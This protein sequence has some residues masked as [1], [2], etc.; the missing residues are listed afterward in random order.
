MRLLDAN[1]LL[2]S[3]DQQAVLHKAAKLWLE[4]VLSGGEAVGIPMLSVAAFLRIST[5]KRLPRLVMRMEDALAAV[6]SWLSR[7]HVSIVHTAD[8]NWKTT[9]EC[10]RVGKVS[11]AMVTDAQLAALAI[12]HGATFYSHDADFARFPRLRWVDP[13]TKLRGR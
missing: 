6:D 4:G 8:T 9:V 13:L 2:L 1:L 3:Y 7:R 10:I 5:D 12:D 11:G